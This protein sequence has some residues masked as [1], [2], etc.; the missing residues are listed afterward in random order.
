MVFDRGYDY[1]YVDTSSSHLLLKD[2]SS[3]YVRLY[4]LSFLRS[5]NMMSTKRKLVG[6]LKTIYLF[7]DNKHVKTKKIFCF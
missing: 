2:T 5:K 7:Y 6:D 3:L 4:F 1:V